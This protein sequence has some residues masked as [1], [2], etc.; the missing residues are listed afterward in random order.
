MRI[1]EM[2]AEKKI[3]GIEDFKRMV[4]DNHSAYSAMLTP[5]ILIASGK[6]ADLEENEKKALDA[7]KDWDYSM[8]GTLI[9]PTLF[10]FIRVE[11]A[12]NIMSDELT[13]LY[14]SSLGRQHDFYI[15]KMVCEGPDEWIDNVNTP[16][17][18]T[19]DEIIALSIS[20]AVDTLTARYGDFGN[21]W[22]WGRISYNE[23]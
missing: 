23:I 8:D 5:L 1:R 15:Y 7:L 22:S 6:I 2:A 18:E 4:T 3:L 13:D 11:I 20:S 12:R 16:V 21:K 14:G 19:M 10:E 17:Q 9:A